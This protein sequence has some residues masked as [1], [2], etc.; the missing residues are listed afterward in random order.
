MRILQVE[1]DPH[2]ALAVEQMLRSGGYKCRT[3]ESGAEAVRLARD[4]AFDLILLD[5]MLPDIDGFE[6]L[7]QLQVAEVDIPIV[8]QTG[9]V[10]RMD[11]DPGLGLTDF[12]LKPYT[13]DELRQRID[14]AIARGHGPDT[15]IG[16]GEDDYDRR[17]EPRENDVA[18]RVHPR[19]RTLKAG[20][21]VSRDGRFATECLV[22]NL[23]K[24]GAALRPAEFQ[25]LPG[26]FEL[27]LRS[28]PRR[29]CEVCWRHGDKVG[30]RFLDLGN[31]RSH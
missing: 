21:I 15:I 10:S 13:R 7:R 19:F 29:T 20:R 31:R 16:A 14:Q 17:G 27:H 5:I 18:R 26:A 4:E 6:V 8:V 28:G 1:D 2:T 23:S 3:T 30:V 9:M 12:L 24:G 11:R 22:L 25:Q